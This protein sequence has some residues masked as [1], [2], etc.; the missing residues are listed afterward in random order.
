MILC[1]TTETEEKRVEQIVI[2]AVGGIKTN[3]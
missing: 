1:E 3:D 2:I